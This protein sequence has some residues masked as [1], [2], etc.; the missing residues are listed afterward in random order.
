LSKL[1][2]LVFVTAF[3]VGATWLTGWF[4]FFLLDLNVW[5]A[6]L[7]INGALILFGAELAGRLFRRQMT[8]HSPAL[9]P[10]R[11]AF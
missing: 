5:L 2:L 7:A 4:G 1:S 10:R 6:F 9:P 8:N 3:E 11:R